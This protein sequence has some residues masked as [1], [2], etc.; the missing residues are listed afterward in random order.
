M[1]PFNEATPSQRAALA[2][3]KARLKRF[4]KTYQPPQSI[5]PC[6]V[7][8]KQAGPRIP[9]SI[10]TKMVTD[11]MLSRAIAKYR[12]VLDRPNTR[13]TLT[14]ILNQVCEEYGVTKLDLK[15]ARRSRELVVPRQKAMWRMK[16]ETECSLPAI[17]RFFHRDHTTILYGV[18]RHQSKIDAGLAV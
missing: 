18:L 11:R 10:V 17:G 9:Q 13:P 2:S 14:N 6:R 4:A 15:S 7:Y 8:I 1:T 5:K 12:L 16:H 3:H